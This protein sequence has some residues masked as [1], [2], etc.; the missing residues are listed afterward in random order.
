MTCLVRAVRE[1]GLTKER[2][3]SLNSGIQQ[4][5]KGSPLVPDDEVEKVLRKVSP[6]GLQG[7]A[8]LLATVTE[9][10]GE[11]EVFVAIREG[12]WVRTLGSQTDLSHP[13]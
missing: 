1:P 8:Q 4:P 13:T 6:S 11:V 3:L 2:A 12:A 10:A 5:G 9:G 7:A